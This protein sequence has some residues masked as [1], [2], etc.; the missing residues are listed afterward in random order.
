MSLPKECTFTLGPVPI[1]R[2]MDCTNRN[3]GF[4]FIMPDGTEK[5]FFTQKYKSVDD[6]VLIVPKCTGAGSFSRPAYCDVSKG[7]EYTTFA[8]CQSP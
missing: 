3:D 7:A 4:A 6:I 5:Q 1:Y 2:L 8:D